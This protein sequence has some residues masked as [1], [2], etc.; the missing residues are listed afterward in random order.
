[1]AGSGSKSKSSKSEGSSSSSSRSATKR[2]IKELGV[3]EKE[4][5]AEA[6]IERLGPVN[7]GELLEWE[8]VVNGRG[9][10]GGYDDGRWLLHISIPTE[11]PNKP[12]KISFVT[13]VVH[14]NIALA[15]G[16]ICLDLLKDAWTPAYGI[17]ESVRAV[18]MLLG[19][20]ETDSPLNVD[21]AALIRAGDAVG[22]RRLVE[23]WVN[24]DGGRYQGR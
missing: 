10:G 15:T 19:C 12:P 8:A 3:W 11:Y 23:F 5:A 16:E 13:P 17:L 14:A 9:I 18:R 24:D 7:E 20:P 4:R 22:A 21:V 6:G 2:L 1:M